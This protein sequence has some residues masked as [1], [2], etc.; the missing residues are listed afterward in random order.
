[1]RMPPT[2]AGL[3]DGIRTTTGSP[4]NWAATGPTRGAYGFSVHEID[5][6]TDDAATAADRR[7]MRTAWAIS[8]SAIV[9]VLV[10]S[11]LMVLGTI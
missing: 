4:P 7:Q 5:E 11:L 8:V 1:M 10:A 3:T 9:A 2:L 6:L